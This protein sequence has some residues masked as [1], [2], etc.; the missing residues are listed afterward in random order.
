MTLHTAY[1]CSAAI[2]RLHVLRCLCTVC[3]H[4]SNK[5]C[6]V[7]I[8]VHVTNVVYRTAPFSYD[9]D[10]SSAHPRKLEMREM[11]QRG[12]AFQVAMY[13]CPL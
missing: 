9:A 5:R 1:P 2:H 7:I 3:I 13:V 11:A 6:A 8:V 12:E 4:V 10:L